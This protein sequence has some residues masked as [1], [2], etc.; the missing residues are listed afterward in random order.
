MNRPAVFFDRDNTLI[1]CDGY[2]GDPD[3]VVLVEG[4]AEAVARVRD[5]GFAA[6]VFSNQSGVARGMFPEEAV[7]AVNHR[8]DDLLHEEDPRATIDRHDFCPYHPTA[9][10]ERYRVDSELRK[11]KPGMIYQAASVLGLDLKR[12]WVVGDA[13]RDIAAGQAA[14]L[15]TVLLKIASLPPSPATSEGAGAT[16]D[17][18]AASL[19]E[20]IDFIDRHRQS[21]EASPA[22]PDNGSAHQAATPP[23]AAPAS[24]PATPP[25]SPPA[26][27]D[28][29]TSPAAP[30]AGAAA[31]SSERSTPSTARV[32]EPVKLT[33]RPKS[34]EPTAPAASKPETSKPETPKQG[35]F[36]VKPNQPA[37]VGMTWGERM[38]LAKEGGSVSSAAA[39]ARPQVPKQEIDRPQPQP[40]SQPRPTPEREPQTP[41]TAASPAPAASPEEDVADEQ[42]SVAAEASAHQTAPAANP[43]ADDAVAQADTAE[44][45]APAVES[46]AVVEPAAETVPVA[47]AAEPPARAVEPVTPA[48]S[49]A[50]EAEEAEPPVSPSRAII[51]STAELPA[52]EPRRGMRREDL[53]EHAYDIP[54]DPDVPAAP[55]ARRR[56]EA[57]AETRTDEGAGAPAGDLS[58]VEALLEQMLIELRRREDSAADF[59]AS[60]LVA[61]ITQVLALA[62]LF[63]AYFNKDTTAFQPTLLVSI[64][65]QTLT[66][67]LLIMG[68]QK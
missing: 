6:V 22:T 31:A 39:A 37:P 58:R 25:A 14:G 45:D 17:F 1:A 18:V 2:L 68:R 4:A 12:S 8:L 67:S 26:V 21:A 50:A 36:V 16:P 55:S 7:H 34:S 13:P 62:A 9:K 19:Q 10:V 35:G 23:A 11:P 33:P 48:A 5:M 40:P 52:G 46:S 65:L 43:P 38:R 24:P 30:G 28:A 44:D 42:S 64:A 47:P 29:W 61:G 59:S 15:R 66:I 27:A 60:K 57:A 63:Y 41:M 32:E 53:L 51:T 56:R 20:A 49:V 3:K 54:P